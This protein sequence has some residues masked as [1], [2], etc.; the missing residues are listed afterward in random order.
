M[1]P[2]LNPLPPPS[3]YHPSGSSQCTS[4]KLPVSFIEPGLAISRWRDKKAVVHIHN[5]A[6]F[7]IKT[8]QKMGTEGTYLNI[9]KATYVSLYKRYSQWWKTESISPKIRNKTRVFTFTSII[10]HS[11]RNPSYSNQRRK[12]SKMN[13]D[14]K[15]RSKTLTV[16]RWHDAVHR[17]P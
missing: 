1:F 2:I 5:S 14:W 12:R 10:Q 6:A 13:S 3:P 9:V 16:C 7:M 11:Y 8:L 17:K 15:R 4:P